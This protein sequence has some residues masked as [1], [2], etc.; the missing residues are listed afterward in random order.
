MMIV[1]ADTSQTFKLNNKCLK[2]FNEG[3]DC[4]AEGSWFHSVMVCGKKEY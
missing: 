3:H 1:Y 2:V 4:T